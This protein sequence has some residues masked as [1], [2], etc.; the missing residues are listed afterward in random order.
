MSDVNPYDEQYYRRWAHELPPMTHPQRQVEVDLHHNIL[1]RTARLNPS[2]ALL[3]ADALDVPGS[4]FKVLAPVDMAL[5]A[6]VHLFYGGEIDGALR[7]LVDIDALLRRPFHGTQAE[8]WER[9]WPRVEA[10]DLARPAFYGL[11]YAAGR[12]GTQVPPEIMQAAQAGAP[13]AAVLRVMDGIVRRSLFPRPFEG[14]DRVGSMARGAAYLRSHW[15]KM[16][17]GMLVRHLS[18][19]FAARVRPSVTSA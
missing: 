9:F 18:L 8:F 2:A 16:P 10:L 14:H 4:K 15:V 19:K 13:S 12:L 11:R 1:M 6:I 3:L 5:H 7:E 17:P